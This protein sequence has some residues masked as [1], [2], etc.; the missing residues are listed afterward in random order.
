MTLN[1]RYSV[2]VTI[3][4][5]LC[6]CFFYSPNVKC[7]NEKNK[8]QRH[9]RRKNNLGGN[10]VKIKWEIKEL[11]RHLK[12]CK[13]TIYNWKSDNNNKDGKGKKAKNYFAIALLYDI[14]EWLV[15]YQ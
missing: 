10:T 8:Y 13:G 11:K 12:A 14:I 7:K 5:I 15:W 9:N 4:A 2:S 3:I 6:L 1:V